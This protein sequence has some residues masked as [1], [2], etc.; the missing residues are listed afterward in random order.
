MNGSILVIGSANTDFVITTQR[1][2]KPGETVLGERFLL[3]PGGKGANQAV[4]AARLGGRVTFI[5]KLGTDLFG[6]QSRAQFL[7]EGLDTTYLVTTPDQASGVAL[8]TVDAHGENSIVVAPGANGTLSAAEVASAR[9]PFA[10]CALVLLQ[11][12]IP[13]PTVVAAAQ[14]AT[15]LGKRVILNPAPARPLPNELLPHLFL[16]TPNKTEAETL[17]GIAITDAHSL[18]AAAQALLA[19]GV[20]HVVIT[21]GGDGAYLC[22]PAGAQ[23]LPAVR[24]QPVDTTAAGD[25]FNG[26]LAVALAEEQALPAAV[27]FANQAA[28]ISVTRLGAQASAPYRHELGP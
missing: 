22:S 16:L 10:D 3:N 11:L 6:E 18:A 2:P 5:A 19:K 9:Q 21:L 23:H 27:A 1:F 25:V 14:V 4:A 7:R 26:A 8:I 24:T 17:T 20:Q 12:E 28:A 15:D 13:L